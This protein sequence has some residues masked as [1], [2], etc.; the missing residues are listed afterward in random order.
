LSSAQ[1][2]AQFVPAAVRPTR[3]EAAEGPLLRWCEEGR[4]G[5][6]QGP[7][8][9]FR[10]GKVDVDGPNLTVVVEKYETKRHRRGPITEL[11]KRGAQDA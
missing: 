10:V 5:K 11:S 4:P 6:E 3:R 2:A 8:S 9:P 1:E 7:F